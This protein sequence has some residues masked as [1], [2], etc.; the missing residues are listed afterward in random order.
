MSGG[1]LSISW[2]LCRYA[3]SLT[4]MHNFGEESDLFAAYL[5]SQ[6]SKNRELQS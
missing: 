2:M 5:E 4:T 3:L 6:L 1:K